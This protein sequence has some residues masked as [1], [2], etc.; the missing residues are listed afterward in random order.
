ML[1]N[2]RSCEADGAADR[3]RDVFLH[4]TFRQSKWH[5]LNHL[6]PCDTVYGTAKVAISTYV[7]PITIDWVHYIFEPWPSWWCTFIHHGWCMIYDSQLFAQTAV[8][9]DFQ[10]HPKGRFLAG[11]CKSG[12]SSEIKRRCS[13]CKKNEN[14]K[15]LLTMFNNDPNDT[16]QELPTRLPPF[17]IDEMVVNDGLFLPTVS[18]DLKGTSKPDNHDFHMSSHQIWFSRFLYMTVPLLVIT[19]SMTRPS[20]A[21]QRCRCDQEHLEHFYEEVFLELAKFGE[22]WRSLERRCHKGR[23]PWNPS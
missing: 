7:R 3:P 19:P 2:R 5:G 1:V 22:A 20:E 13:S 9:G 16:R 8:I 14:Q 4:A 21:I 6:K 11:P 10:Q 17:T 12:H 23:S 15:T 18:L